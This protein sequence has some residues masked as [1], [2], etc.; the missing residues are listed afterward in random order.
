MVSP[1][2]L[3]VKEI[4]CLEETDEVGSDEPYVLVVAVDFQPL[5]PNV[6]ATLYGF[7]D[8]VDTG[9]THGTMLPPIRFT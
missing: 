8:D 5:V 9:E 2:T 1:I 3:A 6:E 7:W 4:K